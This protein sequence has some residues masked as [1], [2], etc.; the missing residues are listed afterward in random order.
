MIFSV[1]N[2]TISATTGVIFMSVFG[3]I[4]YYCPQT[5]F[6]KVMFLHLSVCHSVHK[7]G[8]P[9]R[10]AVGIP[11]CLAAGEWYPSM[12]SGGIPACPG[13]HPGEKLRGLA[14]GSLEAHTVG[15]GI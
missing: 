4:C 8:I 7:G 1:P 12:Y 10:I 13:Q 15:G 9:A 3:R 6:A 11:A 14:R 2:I 5:K